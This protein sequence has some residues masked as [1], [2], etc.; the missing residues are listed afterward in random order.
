MTTEKSIYTKIEFTLGNDDTHNYRYREA[1]S[2]LLQEFEAHLIGFQAEDLVTKEFYCDGARKE[3][4]MAVLK[5]I[6]P[7]PVQPRLATTN[8]L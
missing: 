4:A 3:E 1:V 8:S 6:F 2:Q 5:T 7:K